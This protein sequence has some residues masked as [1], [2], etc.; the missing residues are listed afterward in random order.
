MPH[1]TVKPVGH[2]GSWF[3][4]WQGGSYPCVHSERMSGGWYYDPTVNSG[5]PQW[6]RFIYAIKDAKK[7][8]LTKSNV[9]DKNDPPPWKRAR[10]GQY[11]S[12]WEV[13]DVGIVQEDGRSCFRFRFVEELVNWP[14][15]L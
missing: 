11:L 12:L 7:V 1:S 8:I 15:N 2:S 3:A 6:P 9:K 14:H 4:N 5:L 10:K 13:D